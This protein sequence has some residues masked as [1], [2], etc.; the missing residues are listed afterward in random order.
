[1][2]G[3]S[4]DPAPRRMLPPRA[5][6]MLEP[7]AGADAKE[8]QL[9]LEYGA[10]SV[11]IEQG[12]VAKIGE[13]VFD[14]ADPAVGECIFDATADREPSAELVVPDHLLAGVAAFLNLV[15]HIDKSEPDRAV[16]QQAVDR[17]TKPCA[18]R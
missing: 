3:R 1:M 9:V 10:V 6:E 4:P 18:H 2:R 13:Q 8:M 17:I 7:V 11:R 12:N 5:A 15:G 14:P 16:K